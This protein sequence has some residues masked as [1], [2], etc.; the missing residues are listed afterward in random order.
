MS[1]PGGILT[2]D[3]TVIGGGIAGISAAARIAEAD[4][5][6]KSDGCW[7]LKIALL[8][9]PQAGLRPCLSGIMARLRLGC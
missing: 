8:I 7:K 2:P 1:A 4:P 9:I 3:V 6:I 5:S